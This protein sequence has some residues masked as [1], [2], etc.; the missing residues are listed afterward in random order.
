KFNDQELAKRSKLK[1]MQEDKK[2][3]FVFT[4]YAR[5]SNSLSF[6]NEFDKFSKEEL[7]DNKTKVVVAGRIMAI[8]QTFAVLRDFY[9]RVQLYINK[10]ASPELF[11][12]FKEIDVGDIVG[13]EGT[14]MKTNTGELTIKVSNLTLLSKSLK[15]LPEKWHGLQDEEARARHR[16]LDLIM[17]DESMQT[18]ITRSVILRELRNF[19]D[20]RGYLEVETPVLHP[21]LGGAAARPF[22]THHNTLDRE[23][24]L[25][26]ATEIPLKKLIVGGFEKVYEIGRI[27][28]NEGMDAMHNPEFTTLESYE[29]YISMWEVM[30]LVE[31]IFKYLAN[32]LNKVRCEY[33][34]I[35]LDFS[36]PFKR[37]NMVDLIKEKTKIDFNK[38][39][40]DVDA[41]KIA[42][43]HNVEL[44]PHQKTRG[45]IINA[46]F[47]TF[48]EKECIQPTFVYGHPIEVSPLAKKDPKDQRNT[49][50]FE[51]FIGGKE[52][53]NA[54][55]ELNDP[56]DQFERFNNQLKERDLGNAEANEMDWDFI[57]AL[58][59]G[60]PP[61]GGLGIG[62]DRL[63]MLFA[64]QETIR[65]VLLFPHMR[66]EK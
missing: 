11:E 53:A 34:G 16:Y 55:S 47:E 2:D 5:N 63:V 31:E 10:K 44:L 51:L 37:V 52:F 56:I 12:T 36:Q 38:I 1:Q 58:E 18:F 42:K 61:T 65:N 30:E 15:P 6:K 46:F 17:S 35:N 9:G 26:I 59:Y 50:R 49:E 60:M 24:Y 29:A 64:N 3:P 66:D 45:H 27:F 22:K 4:K 40:S 13:I 48:C 14:P 25:R 21:I 41:I 33:R 54:F 7:H 19:M 39:T 28:R 8:R 23:Y 62:I 20:A 57:N 43:E 32:K